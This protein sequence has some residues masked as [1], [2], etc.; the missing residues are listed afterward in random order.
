MGVEIG[1]LAA[2]LIFGPTIYYHDAAEILQP[3]D[4][5]WQEFPVKWLPFP[6]LLNLC[7]K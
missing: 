2:G 3:N 1:L 4:L 5:W 6:K 7:L